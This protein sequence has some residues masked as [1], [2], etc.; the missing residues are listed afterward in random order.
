MSDERWLHQ[1]ASP[2]LTEIPPYV[3]TGFFKVIEPFEDSAGEIDDL[4][5]ALLPD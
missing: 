1:P 2:S 4:G 3:C 5:L